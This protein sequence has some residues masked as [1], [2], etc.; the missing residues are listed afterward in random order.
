M[1]IPTKYQ[2]D[3]GGEIHD[4]EY[5]AEDCCPNP[6]SELYFCPT[7]NAI[8]DEIELA[9]ECCS[10]DVLHDFPPTPEELEA[11]GQQRLIP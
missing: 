3:T 1:N 5:D 10:D 4:E 8:Y 7:C 11:L 2:C 6:Y 9:K